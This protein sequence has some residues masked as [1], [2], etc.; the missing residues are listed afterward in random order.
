MRF[1]RERG[2]AAKNTGI[3]KLTVVGC[4]ERVVCRGKAGLGGRVWPKALGLDGVIVQGA[5]KANLTGWPIHYIPLAEASR[6]E[7]Q[8]PGLD[9][10]L[11]NKPR[12][13]QDLRFSFL[14]EITHA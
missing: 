4:A 11:G 9:K 6:L 13:Q 12:P 7:S 3:V 8:T 2:Q 5:C 14:V 1:L 10:S